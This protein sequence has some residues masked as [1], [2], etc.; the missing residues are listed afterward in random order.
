MIIFH[1]WSQHSFHEDKLEFDTEK[2]W[3]EYVSLIDNVYNNTEPL[4][5]R[6]G[7][8]KEWGY[9]VLDFDLKKILKWG[10]TEKIYNARKSNRKMLE[11]KDK[12][13]RGEDEIPKD[14]KWDDGEYEGW[15]QYRW[16]DG[17]NAI[18]YVEPI[19]NKKTA[20]SKIIEPINDLINTDADDIQDM[21]DEIQ[22]KEKIQQKIDRW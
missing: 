3:K 2:E 16:G 11:L 5:D 19:K 7:D 6:Y 14:Y 1:T 10:K 18:D 22:T 9:V 17:K 12:F 8:T 21:Y 13:F 20:N 4:K 15:L